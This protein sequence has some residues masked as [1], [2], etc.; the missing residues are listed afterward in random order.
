LTT[1]AYSEG[2]GTSTDLE[3]RLVRRYSPD[4]EKY[5]GWGTSHMASTKNDVEKG[6]SVLLLLYIISLQRCFV[7]DD[8]LR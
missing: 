3:T 2:G 8:D 4:E 1:G 5:A 7:L 6:A